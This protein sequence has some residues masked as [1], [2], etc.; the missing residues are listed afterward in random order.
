[1]LFLQIIKEAPKIHTFFADGQKTIFT[2]KDKNITDT[3]NTCTLLCYFPA[4]LLVCMD[5][6]GHLAGKNALSMRTKSIIRKIEWLYVGIFFYTFKLIIIQPYYLNICNTPSKR[7]KYKLK[8]E[9]CSWNKEQN[10][11]QAPNYKL[12]KKLTK[13]LKN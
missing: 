1:M 11:Q 10:S 12:Y 4:I 5:T 6:N 7:H 13:N 2:W 8:K 3:T 9:N